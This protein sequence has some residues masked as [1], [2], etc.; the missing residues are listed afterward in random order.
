[1]RSANA[2]SGPICG[3]CARDCA[4][5]TPTNC[6]TA[7]ASGSSSTGSQLWR[8]HLAMETLHPQWS[9]YGYTWRRDLNAIEPEQYAARQYSKTRIFSTALSMSSSSGPRTARTIRR[10]A[11]AWNRTDQRDFPVLEEFFAAGATDYL[12]YLF[13]FGKRGDRSQ[14][15]GIVYSFATDRK[16]GFSDDDDDAP[17]SDAAGAFAGDEGARRPRHRLGT[18]RDLSR[19]GRRAARPRRLD[20]ARF[21]RHPAR[22]ASGTPTSAASRRSA[23]PR[24]VRSSSSCSTR[25]SRS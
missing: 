3:R 2:S 17:A 5:P 11:G 25:C 1:M 9:G 15:T 6:S 8:A 13:A 20:H 24:R 12:A 18:A 23:I 7:I 10:C 4:A 14:G 21:G 22:G 16:G 19:R